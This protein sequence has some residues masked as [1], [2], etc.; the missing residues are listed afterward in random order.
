MGLPRAHRSEQPGHSGGRRQHHGTE[1]HRPHGKEARDPDR[2]HRRRALD[3]MVVSA[4]SDTPGEGKR[5]R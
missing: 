2:P 3:D 4:R 1:H 5:A